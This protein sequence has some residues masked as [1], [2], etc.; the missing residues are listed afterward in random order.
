MSKKNKN[1]YKK[2]RKAH[3]NKD[4]QPKE[5]LT[6]VDSSLKTSQSSDC[7]PKETHLDNVVYLLDNFAGESELTVAQ[8]DFVN[9]YIDTTN[10]TQAYKDT[11][12]LTKNGTV[13]ENSI[14]EL[15][16]KE[17]RKPQVIEYLRK[18]RKIKQLSSYKYETTTKLL[19]NILLESMLDKSPDNEQ[20]RLVALREYSRLVRENIIVDTN[21]KITFAP[22]TYSTETNK[23]MVDA[24]ASL[25][26]ENEKFEALKKVIED[27]HKK[28][29]LN[30]LDL[31]KLSLDDL[32]TLK[33]KLEDI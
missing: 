23:A 18:L 30:T 4:K 14:R 15:A 2:Y 20:S 11:I 31:T 25:G 17:L 9:Q 7:P 16:S 10:A 26:S 22:A 33:T 19:V 3:N 28:E 1:K 12:F 13:S 29:L 27:E 21:N 32:N 8:I 5:G 6:N 24:T